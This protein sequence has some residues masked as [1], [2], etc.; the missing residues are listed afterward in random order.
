MST[1]TQVQ[2]SWIKNPAADLSF[3]DFGWILVLL[4][5]VIFKDHLSIIILSVLI[6]SYIHRHYTFALVYGDKE[7]FQKRK[8]IYI[9]LP[10]IAA[11]ATI[12][13]LYFDAFKVLLVAAVLWNMYHTITQ[14]YGIAR[15]YSRKAGY[16]EAWI[17]K[18]LIY[19][20][21]AF[22]FF[23][24]V[25]REKDV[26]SQYQAGSALLNYIGDNLSYFTL[27]SHFFL[28]IA[29]VFTLLFAYQEFKNRH[30]INIPK[31]LFVISILLLYSIFF[32]SLIVGY[33]VFAFSHALEYI[34]FVNIFVNSKYKRKPDS[35]SV[36][37]LASRKQW[38]YSSLFSLGIVAICLVGIKLNENAFEIY[39]VGSSFLHFIYDG[40]IWKVRRP[41]VGKPLDIKYAS[42]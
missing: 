8:Q 23:A 41:E 13:S 19:S 2:K 28:A 31:I 34:A 3:F 20:W 14:K 25:E 35:T 16:G 15:I 4:P 18:G 38:I 12:L 7:E 27:A 37:A 22:L 5:L 17:D 29:I 9:F 24:L 26:I 11:L 30:Q 10:I 42:T 39:I 21:F 1:A 40:L 33:I 36:V 6:V 32:Y